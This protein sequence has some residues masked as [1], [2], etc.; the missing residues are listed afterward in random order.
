MWKCPVCDR[1]NTAATVCPQCGYDRT[2][3]YEQYPTAFTVKSAT[4]TRTLRRQ[5]Q[6]AQS[7]ALMDLVMQWY[8]APQDPDAAEH[9]F[10]RL[11]DSGDPAAQWWLGIA[12]AQG[13]GAKM[14][15]NQAVRWFRKAA[16]QGNV[17]A[18]RQLEEWKPQM[19]NQLFRQYQQ[20]PNRAKRIEYLKNSAEQGYA[21][22]QYELGN[23]YYFGWVVKKDQAQAV[24]W[25]RRA[26]DQG[27]AEAQY[28]L[29][30]CYRFGYGIKADTTQAVKWFRKAADQGYTD[31]QYRLGVLYQTG[32]GVEKDNAQAVEWY[33]R[34]A[35]QGNKYAQSAL[36]VCYKYGWGVPKDQALAAYW[37]AKS[38]D[39]NT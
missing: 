29:G 33:R 26:A 37:R 10:R 38:K 4:P 15:E 24:Q 13:R 7:P 32:D 39:K 2:C 17:W 31:A 28:D 22:A 3:D 21:Q 23:H 19:P 36:A 30:S 25:Y 5:W 16:A 27:H 6:E 35:D 12:Y 20:E 18:Q 14:D 8:N 11:A 1:E 34:A 9:C